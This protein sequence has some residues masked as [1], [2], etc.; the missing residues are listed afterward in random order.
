M[1][2][3]K[4]WPNWNW[5]ICVSSPSCSLSGWAT[6]TVSAPNGDSQVAPTPAE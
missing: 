2:P 6:D 4:D 1:K 5:N 3:Q